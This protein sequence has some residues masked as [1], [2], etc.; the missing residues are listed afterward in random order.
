MRSCRQFGER[1][2]RVERVKEKL[3]AEEEEEAQQCTLQALESENSS[4]DM[5]KL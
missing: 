1:V 4:I 5:K 3:G 2:G